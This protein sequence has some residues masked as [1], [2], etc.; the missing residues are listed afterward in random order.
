MFSSLSGTSSKNGYISRS[1]WQKMPCSP[2]SELVTISGLNCDSFITLSFSLHRESGGKTTARVCCV[3]FICVYL[4]E[5]LGGNAATNRKCTDARCK[6][7]LCNSRSWTHHNCS[8]SK[9]VI[10][11][12][13]LWIHFHWKWLTD[14]PAS[15]AVILCRCCW[16]ERHHECWYE[17]FISLFK[18]VCKAS[19]INKQRSHMFLYEVWLH[20]V[21]CSLYSTQCQCQQAIFHSDSR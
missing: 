17:G 21:C 9:T 14:H 5:A 6:Q 20:T 16:G 19:I 2:S 15:V 12:S 18:Q 7:F 10:S 4:L 11:H 13:H 3:K 1:Q 8:W